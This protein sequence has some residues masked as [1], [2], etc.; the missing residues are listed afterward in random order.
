ML[1]Y[2]YED[3]Q[4]RMY[5]IIQPTSCFWDIEWEIFN[6]LGLSEN[7]EPSKATRSYDFSNIFPYKNDTKSGVPH[8]QIRLSHH[9][10]SR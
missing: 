1:G 8:G 2:I 5:N 9:S 4:Y 6:F 10:A 3:I 7:R